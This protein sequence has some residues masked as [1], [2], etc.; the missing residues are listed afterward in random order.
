[1]N[2]TTAMTTKM[3]KS[4]IEYNNE[5]DNNNKHVCYETLLL[6]SRGIAGRRFFS[7]AQFFILCLPILWWN[8]MAAHQNDT[9]TSSKIS[10]QS[11]AI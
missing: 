8:K 5:H 1:M 11:Q 2:T 10:D 3:T 6:E 7:L 4:H 9:K